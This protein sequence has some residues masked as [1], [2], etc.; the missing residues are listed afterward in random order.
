MVS[1]EAFRALFQDAA[2]FRWVEA[3][4][5][6]IPVIGALITVLV[7]ARM[8]LSKV[9]IERQEAENKDREEDAEIVKSYQQIATAQALENQKLRQDIEAIR[10]QAAKDLDAER[11]TIEVYRRKLDERDVQ[12]REKDDIITMRDHLIIDYQD[13]IARL[14]MQAKS[15]GGVPV[16]FRTSYK[17]VDT[18]RWADVERGT[19]PLNPFN[20][21]DR[22]GTEE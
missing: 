4:A 19:G 9:P 13:W 14:R 6:L 5:T 1:I 16:P 10:I 17:D 18:K 22:K 7:A 21:E 12:L 15:Y 11:S 8:Q 20:S 3:L 2:G